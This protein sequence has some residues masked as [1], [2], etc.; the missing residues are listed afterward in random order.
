[1]GTKLDIKLNCHDSG[2]AGWAVLDNC[3]F[4]LNTGDMCIVAKGVKILNG[5]VICVGEDA[6]LNICDGEPCCPPTPNT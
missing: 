2:N 1:M 5:S 6:Q 4:I 3:K